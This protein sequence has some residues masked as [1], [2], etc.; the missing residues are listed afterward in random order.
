[1]VAMRLRLEA[2]VA[3]ASAFGA[4]CLTIQPYQGPGGPALVDYS[5]DGRGGATVT[6]PSLALHFAGGSGFHFPDQLLIDNVDVMGH[7]ASPC[8]SQSGT[9]ISVVPMPRVSGD[10]VDAALP[11]MTSQLQAKLSGPAVVQVEVDWTT[12]WTF[13]AGEMCSTNLNHIP[14]G[15]STFT[16]FPDG[17][18]VRNDHLTDVNPGMEQIMPGQ[19]VCPDTPMIGG[20]LINN[21]FILNAFW[22]FDR[23]RFPEQIGLGNNPTPDPL[24]IAPDKIVTNYST[25]CL[26]SMGGKY[27]IAS[28]WV[29]PPKTPDV[30]PLAAAYG[31]DTLLSLGVEKPGTPNLQFPW[32]V[33]GAL[34]LEQSSCT[35]A[36]NR[37]IAYTTPQKLAITS[38][39]ATADLVRSQLDGM[40]GGDPGNGN[41]PGF[42][43]SDG[44]T[45]LSLAAPR[46]DEPPPP[47]LTGSFTVWL[48]F[49]RGSVPGVPI[50]TRKG[51]TDG[52]FVPQRVDDQNWI[53]WFRDPLQAGET[54][55]IQPN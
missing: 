55:T 50:P 13:P 19:C 26:N 2:A 48:R 12:R 16:V 42:D 4:A 17:Q 37:A 41:A 28:A 24:G 22:T 20:E 14:G 27:Q 54:I 5:V 3:A 36:F 10:Q 11:T 45:T 51:A 15:S 7:A 32:D 33:H 35:A 18:I 8:W 31:Y 29:L 53:V 6:T 47:P 49:P 30:S 43:V 38:G 39:S 52:W 46:P 21:Q 34:I 40:Y 1:M 23:T 44:P 9:G 25:I